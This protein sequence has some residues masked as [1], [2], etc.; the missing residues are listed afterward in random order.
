MVGFG[1]TAA[2]AT[3]PYLVLKLMWLSGS[4]VGMTEMT[5]GGDAVKLLLAGLTP[6]A[7]GA[8]DRRPTPLERDVSERPPQDVTEVMRWGSH[9]PG[10]SPVRS[11]TDGGR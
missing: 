6:R 8:A 4:N 7:I 2:F 9:V 3:V 1:L 5:D 10:R 11:A